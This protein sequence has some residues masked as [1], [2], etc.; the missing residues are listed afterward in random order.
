MD[1]IRSIADLKSIQKTALADSDSGKII[2]RAC[3][4]GC[5]ARKSLKVIEAL[6]EKLAEDGLQDRVIIRKTGC[7]G[8]CEMGPILVIE[9][10]NIF[11]RL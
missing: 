1:K 11:Y 5:R 8:F 6:E 2:I 7:H 10:D 9:P 3:S 4:T